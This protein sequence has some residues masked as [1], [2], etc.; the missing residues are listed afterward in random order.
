MTKQRGVV[1][2]RDVPTF[3]TFVSVFAFITVEVFL[4]GLLAIWRVG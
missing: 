1:P 2:V 3:W 4:L